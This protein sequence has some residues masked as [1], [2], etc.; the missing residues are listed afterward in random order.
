M[1]RKFRIDTLSIVLLVVLPGVGIWFN[2]GGLFAPLSEEQRAK[3]IVGLCALFVVLFL[4]CS[5]DESSR[6]GKAARRFLHW[7]AKL[8]GLSSAKVGPTNEA[9]HSRSAALRTTL[10]DRHAT[11]WRYRERWLLITGEASL[12]ERF[13]PGLSTAGYALTG[14]IVL[15]Y[16]T[17]RGDSVNTEWLEQIRRLRRCRPVDAIVAITCKGPSIDKPFDPEATAQCIARHARALRWAAPTYLLNA[18]EFEDPGADVIHSDQ[19]I[20][21]TWSDKHIKPD[22]IDASIQCL[23]SQLADAGVV[24]VARDASDS[25]P[26][27]LSQHID[28]LRSALSAWIVQTSQSRFWRAAVH[29]LL[30]APLSKT[31]QSNAWPAIWQTIADHSRQVHGRRVGFSPGTAIAWAATAIIG[32][33]IVGMTVSAQT[34]RATIQA[35]ADTVTNLSTPQA[36]T[37]AMLTLDSLQK[38]L[39]TLETHRRDGAP[40]PKRF[41]LNRDHALFDALW[42]HYA[43]A[44]GRVI[45]SPIRLKLEARLHHLA[46][47]SDA[48][49][50]NDGPEQVQAAYDALKTYLMLTKPERA[51]PTFLT[52][53]LIATAMPARPVDSPLTQG[54]WDDLRTHQIAFY[55]RHLGN[56]ALSIEGD[57]ALIAAARQTIVGVRGIQHSTETLYQHIVDDAKPKYPS[58][59]LA[60][61]LGS[62]TSKGLF[63]TS[64]TLPG[65]FT[66]AAWDERIAKAIDDASEQRNESGDWVLADSQDNNTAP[67]TLKAD[68]RQRYFDDYA[69]AWQSFLNS[70][71]WQSAPTLS[72]TVDQLTLLG[73]AQRSPLVALVNAVVYQAGAGAT[74]ES[75]SA[76][77]IDKA[78]QLVGVDERDPSRQRQLP[79]APLAAAFGPILRLTG[80]DLTLAPALASRK[81]SMPLAATGELSL[82]RYLERVTAMRLKTQQ[83]VASV[84]PD[85]MSRAAAQAMLQGKTSEIADSRDYASR[86]AASLGEQW[87][88]LGALFEAP[89]NQTWQVVVQ[90]AAASLN[91][92]WRTAIVADWRQTFGGRY[93]FA[94]SD[95]DA[96]LPEM[97]RFMRP[98]TGVIARFVATQLAGVVERQGDHWVSDQGATGANHGALALDPAFL[99]A[100]NKLMR[101]ATVLF[102]SGDAQVRYELRACRHPA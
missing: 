8:R 10:R 77:L 15:L 84:D 29:G 102:P 70:V 101:V 52:P 66:R 19:A 44:V 64:A 7:V 63:G 71:R 80:S 97:A 32:G 46:S 2:G 26:A 49:I 83:I 31:P 92:I 57:A 28:T 73:D 9:N 5:Y 1:L 48:E 43:N 40:W 51:D 69:R 3:S 39:D 41:G 47:L 58:I 37:E 87:A 81:P 67:S 95:N 27:E 55:A 68:L 61:L 23:T 82:A 72:G 36:P 22:E 79:L 99:A 20:G 94:D 13:A 14:D 96:S 35:A 34:H 90:P 45:A 65:I 86:V 91:E 78:Q 17:Q 42:P 54:A 75:L 25:Y 62:T 60:T 21:F 76:N 89:L 18:T 56:A 93:P 6:L 38:Q 30:F 16:A 88:G 98:D 33:W 11:R 24:R 4:C 59:S 74:T 12:V 100:L 85:A 53:Q 50:A